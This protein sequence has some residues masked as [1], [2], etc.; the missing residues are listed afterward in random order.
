MYRP[1]KTFVLNA[2]NLLDNARANDTDFYYV[3][4]TTSTSVRGVVASWLVRLSHDQA[5]QVQT[6]AG[7]IVLCS[8]ARHFPCTVPF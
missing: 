7:D 3:K 6:L 4:F 2:T 8:R 5:I 1:S